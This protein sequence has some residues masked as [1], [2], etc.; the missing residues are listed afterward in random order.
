MCYKHNLLNNTLG[1]E[2]NSQQ[3]KLTTGAFPTWY[4]NYKLPFQKLQIV[5]TFKSHISFRP[6][7][8]LNPAP[9]KDEFSI[10]VFVCAA[11]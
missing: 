5:P 3:V 11:K 2:N 8:Y 10:V 1:S 4:I 9:A 7:L 6:D